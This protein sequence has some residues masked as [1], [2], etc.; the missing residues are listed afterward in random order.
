M[1]GTAFIV[2]F[3]LMTATLICLVYHL[4]TQSKL[5]NALEATSRRETCFLF[6]TLF[7][8][9]ASY[10]IRLIYDFIPEDS[11]PGHSFKVCM[12]A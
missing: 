12:I 8:L 6:F 3:V 5:L 1:F 2:M 10:L 7:L 11:N 4:R 9:S